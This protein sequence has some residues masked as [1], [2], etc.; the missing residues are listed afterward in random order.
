MFLGERHGAQL[1]QSYA[2]LDLFVHTGPYETFG[3]AMQE[4]LASGV[5]V[6]ALAA[7]G[8][9]DLVVPGWNGALVRPGDEAAVTRAVA[10]LAADRMRLAGYAATDRAAVS[11]ELPAG[12]AGGG[13][14][15]RHA[16]AADRL[17]A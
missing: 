8:P 16:L 7:G 11:R 13:A 9:M 4:A 14:D 15:Y 5:P 1:A 6:V 12:P 17:P 3:Q 10:G 2:S